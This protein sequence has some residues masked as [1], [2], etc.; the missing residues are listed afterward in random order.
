VEKGSD[1]RVE[2]EGEYDLA[3]KPELSSLFASVI[4]EAVTLDFTKVT[5]VDSLFMQELIRLRH[6]L[7]EGAITL[8]NPN[9]NIRRLL[10]IVGF[11]QLFKIL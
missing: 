4:E 5:Y 10:N 9:A 8:A 6:R 1:R 7:P 3:R 2:L 11:D